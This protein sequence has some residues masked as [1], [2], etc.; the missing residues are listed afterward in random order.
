MPSTRQRPIPEIYVLWHPACALGENLARRIYAWL[1]PGHGLG[2]QVYFRSMTAPDG[3]RG[4]LPI[5]LPGESRP[6]STPT[7]SASRPKI[8]NE[9]IVLP[10]IDANMVADPAWRNW[11]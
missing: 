4:G 11:L 1:R 7:Q 5:P 8:A 3:P 2:P 10:L 9:Q 6:A